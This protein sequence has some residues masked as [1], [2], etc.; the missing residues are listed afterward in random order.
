MYAKIINETTKECQV[1][2][3]TNTAFYKSLGMR[4]IEVERG[5]DGAWYVKG[6]AL[7]KLPTDELLAKLDTEYTRQKTM[8]I[9]QF[10]DDTL[11]NDSEAIE[12]DKASM[13]ELDAWY[14]TEYQKLQENEK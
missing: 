1:G 12:A 10:T 2:I 9:E 7:Q 14:D 13:A 8:L 11:H 6:Y 5:I 4:D 3:G